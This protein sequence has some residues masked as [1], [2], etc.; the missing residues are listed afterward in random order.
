M[1]EV[2]DQPQNDNILNLDY[3]QTLDGLGDPLHVVD[4]ELRIISANS[5]FKKWLTSLEYNSDIKGQYLSDAFPFLSKQVMEE[6][7]RAFENRETIVTSDF[8]LFGEREVYTET[9]KIPITNNGE[10]ARVVTIIRD[11]TE[12]KILEMNLEKIEARHSAYIQRSEQRF[13]T[14]F[15]ESPVSISVFDE[16]GILVQA[17]PACAK[18]FGVSSTNELLGFNIFGDPNLPQS[19]KSRML[20]SESIYFEWSFNFEVVKLHGFYQSNKSGIMN[21]GTIITP[22]HNVEKNFLN[23]WIVQMQDITEFRKA[24]FE[25]QKAKQLSMQFMEF[26]GHDIANNLQA[27]TICTGLLIDAAESSGKSEVLQLLNKSIVACV[28]VINRARELENKLREDN[29]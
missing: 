26:M 9:R 2:S 15:D 18:M 13:R 11:V 19:I 8:N 20:Q 14:I 27:M 4:S 24:S 7:K 5:A 21:I 28:G 29:R 10:V 6:Y 17:N 3:Y 16:E 23:G 1:R 22:V 25:L 12:Y